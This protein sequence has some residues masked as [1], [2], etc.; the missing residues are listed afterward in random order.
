MDSAMNQECVQT[1][2]VSRRKS[3][4]PSPSQSSIPASPIRV[5][6]QLALGRI[7]FKAL[8]REKKALQR[9]A[10][11]QP[12]NAPQAEGTPKTTRGQRVKVPEQQPAKTLRII[13][14]P[15]PLTVGSR[16][17]IKI[18]YFSSGD[19]RPQMH[20]DWES[21][22]QERQHVPTTALSMP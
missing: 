20:L 8:E 11:P 1:D 9:Q 22:T 3:H 15:I 2:D 17:E 21:F 12:G 16:H 14:K 7:T 10:T 6:P 19:G 4:L 18:E 13:S 5:S